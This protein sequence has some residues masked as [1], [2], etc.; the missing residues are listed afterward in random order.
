MNIITEYIPETNQN[1][2][3]KEPLLKALA[4]LRHSQFVSYHKTRPIFRGRA[5]IND[6]ICWVE[7]PEGDHFWADI[8]A[9]RVPK[10]LP[11]VSEDSK[12]DLEKAGYDLKHRCWLSQ[13]QTNENFN[14][15]HS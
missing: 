1:L 5:R 6:A 13:H 4:Q 2:L 15:K 9:A 11:T 3:I 12:R 7:T 8:D 14:F 10:D